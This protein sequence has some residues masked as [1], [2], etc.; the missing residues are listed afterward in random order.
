M[1]PEDRAKVTPPELPLAFE[2]LL[3][4][5]QQVASQA[6]ERLNALRRQFPA[7]AAWKITASPLHRSDSTPDQPP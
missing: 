2:L 3:L 7:D 6:R 1:K 4:E 5:A